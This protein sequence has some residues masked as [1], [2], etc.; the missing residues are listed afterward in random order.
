VAAVRAG[1]PL[2]AP[3]VLRISGALQRLEAIAN[4]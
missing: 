4:S 3:V 1:E 2:V